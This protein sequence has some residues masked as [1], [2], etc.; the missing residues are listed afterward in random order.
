[1]RK[2]L[3]LVLP[4]ALAFAPGCTLLG[5]AGG[6]ALA[7]SSHHQDDLA[8]VRRGEPVEEHSIIPGV[9]VG[10]GVGLI[11]DALVVSA[12]LSSFDDLP[13]FGD[14]CCYGVSND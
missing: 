1:M 14:G 2:L 3:C 5:A 9:V 10:A 7:S 12:V 4:L 11:V 6:G 13:T 8:R